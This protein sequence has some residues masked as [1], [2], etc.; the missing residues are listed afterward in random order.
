MDNILEKPALLK[1]RYA[2]ANQ[3]LFI[4]SKIQKEITR[5]TLLRNK[6]IDSKTDA[7]RITYNKQR[8]YCVSLICK[9]KMSIS[10]IL[11]YIK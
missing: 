10:I 7:D 11:K 2:Q 8:Y 6:F 3:S 5:K 1:K 4:N 9:G